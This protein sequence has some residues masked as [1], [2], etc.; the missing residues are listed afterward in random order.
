MSSPIN[1][2]ALESAASGTEVALSDLLDAVPFNSQ[3][4]IPA[5]AQDSRSKQVLMLAWMDR[6]ALQ[7]T[8]DEGYACYFSRSRNAYWR[9]G[10]TSGHLQRVA[11]VQFDCDADAVL[12][13]VEQT[14][15]ACHTLRDHCFYLEVD[16]GRDPCTVRVTQDPPTQPS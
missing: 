12:L 5:I 8:V 3:G 11:K 9:K 14:G 6:T 2:K 7:R 1:I 16:L 15:A 4:L 10:E 13:S